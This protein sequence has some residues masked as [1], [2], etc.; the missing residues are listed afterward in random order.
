M[1][2]AAGGGGCAEMERRIS[3]RL[4]EDRRQA[5]EQE[6]T[7]RALRPWL[8]AGGT[9]EKFEREWPD[10]RS[11][12]LKER[13]VGGVSEARNFPS[14]RDVTKNCRSCHTP[15]RTCTPD[16]QGGELERCTP[17]TACNEF[18][19]PWMERAGG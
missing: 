17:P 15:Y 6:M 10:F 1:T 9:E 14:T 7:D 4:H 3:E 5:R 8:D 16:L 19:G 13:A 11:R 12:M 2:E 18:D